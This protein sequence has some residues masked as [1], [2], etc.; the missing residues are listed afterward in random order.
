MEHLRHPPREVLSAP[1][2]PQARIG[3]A[4]ETGRLAGAKQVDERLGE[5]PNVVESEVQAFRSGRRHDV[6]SV[7]RQEEPPVAHRLADVAAHAGHALLQ[8]RPFV[9]RPPGETESELELLPDALV[10]PPGEILVGSTL[11]VQTTPLRRAEAEQGEASVVV[12]IDELVVRGRDRCEDAEPAVRVLTRELAEDARGDARSTDPM[13]PVAAGDDVAGEVDLLAFM[14]VADVGA[15]RV[16]VMEGYVR[17][18]EVKRSTRI[19]SKPDEI[20]DDLRLP[21]DDD[22]PSA[23]E[24]AQ[25]DPM[26]LS[27][28]LELDASMDEALATEPLACS[29]LG[30]QVDDGVLDDPCTDTGFDVRTAAELEDDRVDPLAVKEVAK[31]EARRPAADDPDLRALVSQSAPSSERTRSAIAKAPFAAGTPQ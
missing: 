24:L 4:V 14:A 19:D 27:G 23:G 28:E 1:H 10:R 22:R 12:G 30:E 31:E 26:T 29:S 18:L 13:E 11:E 15:L 6:R 7:A 5:H 17:D 2:P 8:D 9:K 16:E 20:L 21:V 3:V 25:G